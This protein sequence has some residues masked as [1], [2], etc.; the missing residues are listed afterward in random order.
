MAR[1]HKGRS[2]HNAGRKLA[3]QQEGGGGGVRSPIIWTPKMFFSPS[4]HEI[5]VPGGGG[6][7]K[8]CRPF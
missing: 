3:R 8:G 2:A 1:V 4:H 6:S 5:W 7:R